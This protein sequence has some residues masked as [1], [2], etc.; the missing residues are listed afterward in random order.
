MTIQ[1][2]VVN[3]VAVLDLGGRLVL[4]D[5]D[6]ALKQK[7]QALL[8]GGST[9]VILNLAEVSYVD[10]AGL[11]SLVAVC[12]DARKLGGAIKLH[13]ASKRLHDLFVMSRLVNVLDISESE[14][15]ALAGFGVIA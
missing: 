7:I 10:S 2:R 1:E 5:G 14:S 13:S 15:H 8:A 4:G 9:N 11:G 12:L 3:S 6:E